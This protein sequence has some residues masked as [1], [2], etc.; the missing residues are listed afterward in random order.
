MIHLNQE[1][2]LTSG[3][4]I[5]TP[6]AVSVIAAFTPDGTV[7]DVTGSIVAQPSALCAT[8][9][10]LAVSISDG[11]S[12]ISSAQVWIEGEDV[13]GR[14]LTERWATNTAGNNTF[15]LTK[16]FYSISLIEVTGVDF[17]GGDTLSI[18][19]AALGVFGLPFV[20]ANA[21]QILVARVDAS[22]GSPTIVV[23]DNTIAFASAPNTARRFYLNFSDEVL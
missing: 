1:I 4:V 11:D 3:A 8:G 14:A 2:A 13:L 15:P 7:E 22:P 12:S 10:A 21:N 9:L 18:G 19:T 23:A 5:A 17:T 6:T 20:I 16:P